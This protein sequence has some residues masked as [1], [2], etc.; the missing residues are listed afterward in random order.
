MSVM[1]NDVK[2]LAYSV[3]NVQQPTTKVFN[4]SNDIESIVKACKRTFDDLKRT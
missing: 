1:I 3:I 2:K 4:I